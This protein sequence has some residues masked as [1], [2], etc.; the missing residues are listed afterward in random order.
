MGEASTKSSAT[1]TRVSTAATVWSR[2]PVWLM[3]VLLVVVTIAV[4]WPATRCSFI[5]FDDDLYVY[6]NAHLQSGLSWEGVKWAFRNTEQAEYWAPLMWLSHIVGWQLF[7]LHPWGHHLINVLLHAANTALVFLVFRR[8]TGATWR[9]AALAALFGLHPLRVESVAWVTERKDVL[10]GFFGLLA[11]MAY[12]RYAEGRRRQPGGRGSSSGVAC[13]WSLSHLPASIF[14]LLCLF[15]FA[16][17]LMSK[18]MLVTWPFVLLLLDYWPLGRLEPV[19]PNSRLSTVLRLVG[20]KIP[21]FVLAALSSVVTLVV[22]RQGGT[23]A[24]AESLSLG[25]RVGNGLISYCRYLGK[26]FWPTDLAVYYPHPGQWPLEE[27]LLA[28]GLL[29]GISALL[30]LGRRR[31]PFLLMGWLWFVGTLVPNIGLVQAGG[32]AMAVRFTY[33]PA[34]GVLTLVLWGAYEVAGRRRY[35]AVALSVAGGAAIVLC[36]ALT[37][38]QIGYWRDSETLFRRALAVTR[39]NWLAHN[40]LGNAL[41]SKGETGEAIAQYQEAVRLRPSYAKAHNN[42]GVALD[43]QGQTD[44]AI[45]QYQEAVRLKPDYIKARINLGAAFGQKGRTDEA[46]GQYQEVVRLRPDYADAHYSLGVALGR[47]GRTDEAIRQYQEVVRLRPGNVA[48]HINLGVALASK[49]QTDDAIRQYQEALRLQ[50]DCTEAHYNLGTVLGQKG[51]TDEAIRQFQ[52]ALRLKPD[53]P[54]ARYNLGTVLSRKGETDEATRQ[55]QEVVRLRPDYADAHYSL[56]RVLSQKGQ[57]DEA[58]RHFQEALRLRPDY[59]SARRSLDAA[60]AAK[61]GSLEPP[62]A[63]TNR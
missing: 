24:G 62:G 44:E 49:G 37:Q 63:G 31:Y 51:E 50:Q 42:L 17:G 19:P 59:A 56:G 5:N 14:Y 18:P 25:A 61:A 21:F 10:S 29:L 33:I 15:L 32:V 23:M 36:A 8:M 22:Q 28:S 2:F 26:L 47:R 4:F 58:I 7:G 35:G 27:V 46:I 54:Q 30:F 48:A 39:D 13:R 12:A 38:Q 55:Y 34:I 57:T 11:L 16:L 40:N 45:R 3:A 41:E 53:Y 20:E 6:Q 43:R 60:L 9:S 1:R 52:E